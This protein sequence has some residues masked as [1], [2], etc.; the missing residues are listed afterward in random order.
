MADKKL[1]YKG[2]PM[3]R[4]GDTIY[5]GNTEEKYI[6]KIQ[7]NTTKDV[8]GIKVADKVTVELLLSDRDAKDRVQKKSEKTGLYAALDIGSIW[9]ERALKG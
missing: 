7:I 4:C 3:A 8:G 6:V 9:L 5:Y 1:T 2:K